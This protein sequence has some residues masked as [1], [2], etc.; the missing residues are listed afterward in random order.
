MLN[1]TVLTKPNTAYAIKFL[2]LLTIA[3]G[4]PLLGFHSRW[5]TGPIVNAA[6]I[7]SVYLLGI[8]GALLIG[9]LP[10]TIALGTGL[11]PAVLAPMIPFIILSNTILVLAMDYLKDK[12]EY[13][14]NLFI[15]SGLKYLFLFSTSSLVVSLFLKQS[16]A[17]QIAQIMSW[18]QF[19]TAI[20]GGILAWS[21]L[22]I[23]KFKKYE[24]IHQ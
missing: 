2:A 13:G 3:T 7:L 11:L 15:A 19:F 24:K 17:A 21:F 5:I 10:S 8:R 4:A 18:P 14:I 1:T 23:I 12:L 9:I 6:L 20:I 16:L 22:E